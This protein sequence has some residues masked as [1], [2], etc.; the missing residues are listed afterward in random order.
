MF[1]WAAGGEAFGGFAAREYGEYGPG[2]DGRA[3][4]DDGTTG[5]ADH[6]GRAG[7]CDRPLADA[8]DVPV[9]VAA[10]E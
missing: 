7:L 8:G 6:Q 2:R 5:Y 3:H 9:A 10:Q 4:A 1:V